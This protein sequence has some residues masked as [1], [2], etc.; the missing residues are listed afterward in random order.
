MITSPTCGFIVFTE[1][2]DV[3]ARPARASLIAVPRAPTNSPWR[4]TSLTG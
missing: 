3:G 2:V 4:A 1:S